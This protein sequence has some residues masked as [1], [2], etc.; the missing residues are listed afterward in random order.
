[1]DYITKK[2]IEE[3]SMAAPYD[4]W[5]ES[6]MSW[7]D[8]W[9]DRNKWRKEK[10]PLRRPIQYLKW[11]RREPKYVWGYRCKYEIMDR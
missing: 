6:W 10:P 9:T 5:F 8:F 7:I 2:I 11:M 1:M 3:I 4:E